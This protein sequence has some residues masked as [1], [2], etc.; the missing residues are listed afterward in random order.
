MAGY[1]DVLLREAQKRAEA[2]A[3]AAADEQESKRGRRGDEGDASDDERASQGSRTG[4]VG[5]RPRIFSR[6]MSPSAE[7]DNGTDAANFDQQIS[8]EQM[9]KISLSSL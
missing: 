8:S 5:T 6:A 9:E 3:M 4:D 2:A 7:D 1:G